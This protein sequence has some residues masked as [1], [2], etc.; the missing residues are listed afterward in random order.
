MTGKDSQDSRSASASLPD[1]SRRPDVPGPVP[2]SGERHAQ[3]ALVAGQLLGWREYRPMRSRSLRRLFSLA[4]PLVLSI[5]IASVNLDRLKY[6]E[7]RARRGPELRDIRMIRISFAARVPERAVERQSGLLLL[8]ELKTGERRAMS[9][10][11]FMKGTEFLRQVVPS[12]RRAIELPFAASLAALGHAVWMPDYA[13]M[14]EGNGV[15][16]YCVPDSLAASGADGLAAS[17]SW[18]AMRRGRGDGGYEETGRLAVMGYSE[19]GTAAMAFLDS[20]T[21]GR[22]EAPGLELSAGYPM[23]AFL[24]LMSIEGEHGQEPVALPRPAF[25]IYM[26]MG[27]ARAYPEEIRVRDVLSPRTVEYLVPLFDG[28]RISERLDSRIARVFGRRKGGALD[29]DIY[30]DAY[31]RQVRKDPRLAPYLRMREERRL[32]RCALPPRLPVILA[33][34]PTDEVVPFSNSAG[35]LEWARSHAPDSSME[36]V[37][38][39][40]KDHLLGA[41]EALLYAVV[42]FDKREAARTAISRL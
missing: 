17:R 42:D 14:G 11:V 24:D 41:I 31:L 9:W 2:I 36:L 33:A 37:T 34:T 32:D 20:L 35:A 39:A 8:P 15:Q 26:A 13:G 18:L 1:G 38:L 16:E 25:Q 22:L 7:W 10:V 29:T 28:T 3:G 40:A 19:G 21:Q 12:R 27:W 6:S 4:A 23:G 5:Q 30:S